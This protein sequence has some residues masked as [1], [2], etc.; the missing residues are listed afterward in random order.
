MQTNDTSYIVINTSSSLS[1]FSSSSS[2]QIHWIIES[3]SLPMSTRWILE[4]ILIWYSHWFFLKSRGCYQKHQLWTF[5]LAQ[6]KVEAVG[7][8]G[9]RQS[10]SLATRSRVVDVNEEWNIVPDEDGWYSRGQ[11]KPF[12]KSA[13]VFMVEVSCNKRSWMWPHFYFQWMASKF[14]AWISQIPIRMI[15]IRS[16]CESQPYLS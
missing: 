3:Y 2:S 11:P 10:G 4:E 13:T 12:L 14:H 16:R 6:A 1:S 8:V 7:I 9:G 5:T 15:M